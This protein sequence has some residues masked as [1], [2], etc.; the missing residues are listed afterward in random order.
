[1]ESI[2]K[3]DQDAVVNATDKT[4][5]QKNAMAQRYMI[6]EFVREMW[7]AWRTLEGLEVDEPYEV[8]KLGHTP[9]NYREPIKA[10]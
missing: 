1:M 10:K 4:A 5:A 6:K 7:K 3:E 2:R 9:H 8:A